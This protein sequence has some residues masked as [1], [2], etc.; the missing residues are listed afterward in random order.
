MNYYMSLITIYT[1]QY[2]FNSNLYAL[3]LHYTLYTF[4]CRVN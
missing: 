1:Q 4:M 2:Q 3:Y